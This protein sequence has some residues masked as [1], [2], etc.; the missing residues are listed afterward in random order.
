MRY[1]LLLPWLFFAPLSPAV[2]SDGLEAEAIN[3]EPFVDVLDVEVVN[4]EST[5]GSPTKTA[6]P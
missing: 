1:L 2:A 5:C 3:D 6:S 4:I